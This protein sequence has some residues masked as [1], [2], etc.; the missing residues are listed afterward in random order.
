MTMA[1]SINRVTL[2]GNLGGDAEIREFGNGDKYAKFSLAT[3]ESWKDRNTGEKKERTQW[4][5]IVVY[6]PQIAESLG[7]LLKGD[8]V[9]VDGQLETRTWE[10][11]SG[12]KRYFTEV[13]VRPYRGNIVRLTPRP[14][15]DPAPKPEP[16]PSKFDTGDDD[17]LPF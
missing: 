1:S 15:A 5:N 17:S 3:G 6:I 7:S 8:K 16:E 12:S 4:H 11:K 2:L 14:N 9:Y 13:A 10:D